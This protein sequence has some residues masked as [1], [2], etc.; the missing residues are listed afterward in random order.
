MKNILILILLVFSI[1]SCGD[2]TQEMWLEK[3]GS[4][5]VHL[6]YNVGELMGL[7]LMMDQMSES[8]DSMKLGTTD[9]LTSILSDLQIEG[10]KADTTISFYDLA[11][12]EK[13]QPVNREE[14]KN[15]LL[16]IKADR[17][18][19]TLVMKLI[20]N[21]DNFKH[22]EEIVR[23]IPVDEENLETDPLG[24]LPDLGQ[25]LSFDRQNFKI[26]SYTRPQMN[27]E[28]TVPL[29]DSLQSD[30]LKFDLTEMMDMGNIISIYH[31]PYKI[32]TCTD[33]NAMIQGKTMTI[34]RPLSDLQKKKSFPG[35]TVGFKKKK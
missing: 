34:K 28:E 12:E 13:D 11:L 24:E 9:V 31:F 15:I 32:K 10:N 19:E 5:S 20:V 29:T 7:F 3:D 17:D 21:F 1:C 26:A 33:D 6:S 23:S 18:E 16:N 25:I 14:L 35:L 4:G 22:L 2:L 30:E 8:T 27:V